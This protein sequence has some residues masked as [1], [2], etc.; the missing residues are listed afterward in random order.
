[1]SRIGTV[2]LS[3]QESWQIVIYAQ[4]KQKKQHLEEEMRWQKITIETVESGKK[5]TQT[6]IS[7]PILWEGSAECT[8]TSAC[9][10]LPR[11]TCLFC[12]PIFICSLFRPMLKVLSPWRHQA[13]CRLAASWIS[14]T[15]GVGDANEPSLKLN[16]GQ[17]KKKRKKDLNNSS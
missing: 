15:A 6:R 2:Y 17:I 12:V 4:E 11:H 7:F 1:M 14:I 5:T 13:Q 8:H 3:I 9:E 10:M 16:I